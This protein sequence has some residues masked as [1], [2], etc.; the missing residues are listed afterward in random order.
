MPFII[1]IIII[2]VVVVVVVISFNEMLTEC[3]KKHNYKIHIN[4]L[5]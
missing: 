5:D 3:S 4:G 2:V 1:I